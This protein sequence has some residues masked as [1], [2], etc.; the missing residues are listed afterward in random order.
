VTEVNVFP[1]KFPN[2][3][4]SSVQPRGS[5]TRASTV[6]YPWKPR[7]SAKSSGRQRQS[8]GGVTHTRIS[9]EIY[10]AH[11]PLWH[12]RSTNRLTPIVLLSRAAAIAEHVAHSPRS[13]ISDHSPRQRNA[14]LTP[15]T[16][17]HWPHPRSRLHSPHPDSKCRCSRHRDVIWRRI[18]QVS[19]VSYLL[20]NPTHSIYR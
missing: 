10:F 15:R 1:R 18:H 2:D 6:S 13:Q 11:K 9:I 5:E 7:W 16:R 12:D 4:P 3:F 14:T 20:H 19:S 17:T 8:S